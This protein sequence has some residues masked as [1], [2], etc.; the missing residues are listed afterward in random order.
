MPKL[1]VQFEKGESVRWLGHLDILRTFERAIRRA[2]LPIAYTAGFNPRERLTFISALGTGITGDRE[3]L[4]IDL[5]EEISCMETAQRLNAVLPPGFHVIACG[6]ITDDE[7]KALLKD[8]TKAL[9]ATICS[10]P[11]FTDYATIIAAID[12]LLALPSIT[13]ERQREGRTRQLDARQHL[14]SLALEKFDADTSR[15]VITMIVGQGESGNLKPTEVITLLSQFLPGIKPRRTV[16]R[17]MLDVNEQ[18][19]SLPMEFA[20]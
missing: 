13:L 7:A 15:A 11:V 6:N 14:Y 1:L 9:Y 8:I 3:P 4:I 19:I 18:P 20:D 2:S 17:M 5:V 16:R 12:N 10:C